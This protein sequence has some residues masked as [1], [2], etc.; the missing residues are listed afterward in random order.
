MHDTT[1]PDAGSVL[2]PDVDVTAQATT[3]MGTPTDLAATG[4]SM[5]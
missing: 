5:N 2:T 4:P 1:A 3:P